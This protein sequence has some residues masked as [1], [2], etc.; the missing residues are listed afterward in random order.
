MEHTFIKVAEQE[1]YERYICEN[2]GVLKAVIYTENDMPNIPIK[3][4]EYYRYLKEGYDVS[5]IEEGREFKNV[6]DNL[7]CNEVI[8]MDVL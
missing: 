4:I 5:V 3:R 1:H 8:L 6:D 7:T 2:C